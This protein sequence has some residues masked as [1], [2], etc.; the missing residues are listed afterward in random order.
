[1]TATPEE[2]L[3]HEIREWMHEQDFDPESLDD[4][5]NRDKFK[6]EFMTDKQREEAEAF[7]NRFERLED[8]NCYHN[9]DNDQPTTCP[10]CRVVELS[11]LK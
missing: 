2:I 6:E 8:L 9:G 3:H 10:L 11:L 1:M 5:I 7:M 4:L